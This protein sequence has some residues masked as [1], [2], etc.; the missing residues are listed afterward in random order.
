MKFSNLVTSSRRKNRKKFFKSHSN[1]RRKIMASLLS[2][3]LQEKYHK[4]SLPVRKDDEVKV[5]RGIMKG[6]IGKVVQCH[7]KNFSIYVDKITRLKTGKSVS[8]FPI[9]HSNVVI[10]GL[11]MTNERKTLLLEKKTV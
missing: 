10:V 4:K 5:M 7:R 6:R 2:K 3:N 9:S 11:S 8:Y 1:Q